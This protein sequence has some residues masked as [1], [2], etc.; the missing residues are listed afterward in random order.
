MSKDIYIIPLNS[1]A[2]DSKSLWFKVMYVHLLDS[3]NKG[4]S[5]VDQT[6]A[7]VCPVLQKFLQIKDTENIVESQFWK[8]KEGL[9]QSILFHY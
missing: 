1:F 7:R 4:I 2:Q 3:G 6:K 5:L 8:L 9:V